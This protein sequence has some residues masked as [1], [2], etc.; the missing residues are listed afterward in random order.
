MAVPLIPVAV[1]LK[2]L[3]VNVRA[4]DPV[5]IEEAFKPERARAPE[6]AVRLSAPAVRV[7]PL[8]AVNNPAD[9]I[10]PDP[11]VEMFP[12]V[13]IEVGVIAPRPIVRPGVVVEFAQVAVTPLLA[14]V[15]PTEVTVPVVGVVQVGAKVVPAEV[16]TCPAVPLASMAVTPDPD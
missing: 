6:V 13:E 7:K 12:E 4:L 16:R 15:V 2:L 10:V 5:L 9:V 14:A 1:V 8:E 11:V 3:E